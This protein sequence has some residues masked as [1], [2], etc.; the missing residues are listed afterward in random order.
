MKTFKDFLNEGTLNESTDSLTKSLLAVVK[1]AVKKGNKIKDEDDKE[2]YFI[3][4]SDELR[5]FVDLADEEL[6]DD[7]D[8]TA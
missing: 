2:E 1:K 5:E 7:Y 8:Y 4:L 6:P 3:E